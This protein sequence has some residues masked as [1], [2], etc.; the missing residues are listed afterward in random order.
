MALHYEKW[1]ENVNTME[2]FFMAHKTPIQFDSN[3]YLSLEKL[4]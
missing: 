3:T 1:G 4:T 2:L